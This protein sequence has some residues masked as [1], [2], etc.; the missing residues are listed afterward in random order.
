MSTVFFR[1]GGDILGRVYSDARSCTKLPRDEQ[2]GDKKLA[3]FSPRPAPTLP[4]A[5]SQ[6]QGRLVGAF[7][8]ALE[9][10]FA[11]I[12]GKQEGSARGPTNI[13]PGKSNP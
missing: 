7:G 2:D 13:K 4:E 5:S 8:A 6:L 12:I 9:T 3:F 10:C 1:S 11:R